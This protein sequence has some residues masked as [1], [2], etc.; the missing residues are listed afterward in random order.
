MYEERIKSAQKSYNTVNNKN[1]SFVKILRKKKYQPLV[2]LLK[3]F[4]KIEKVQFSFA[5]F[6]DKEGRCLNI[7][8]KRLALHYYFEEK[9]LF[10]VFSTEHSFKAGE[11]KFRG[12]RDLKILYNR[13][14]SYDEGNE[15]ID[16]FLGVWRSW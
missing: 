15:S 9:I 2:R 1:Y 4:D 5:D 12:L 7:H 8:L 6:F 14:K 3:W 11:V 16:E 13:L 10:Y